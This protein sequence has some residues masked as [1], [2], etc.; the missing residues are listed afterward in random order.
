MSIRVVVADDHPIVLKG[1]EQV[2]RQDGDIEV[3]AACGTGDEALAEVSRQNPDVLVLDLRMAGKSGLD[4]LAALEERESRTRVVLLTATIDEDEA[5]EAVR[6]GVRGIV[7]KENPPAQLLGAIR[8]V[9][10]GRKVLDQ[11]LLTRSLER[12]VRRSTGTRQAA[13]VLTARELEI[14]GLVARGL[15]NKDLAERLHITEGTVKLH[16]HN[17]YDKLHVDGR[18]ALLLYAQEKGLI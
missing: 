15:R 6:L 5:M 13:G 4:V 9:H 14:I 17:I 16:L 12:S 2:L 7:L 8:D 18:V 10:H 3:V 1:I 11:E